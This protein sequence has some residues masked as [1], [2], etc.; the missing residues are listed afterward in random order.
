[1][2]DWKEAVKAISSLPVRFNV[3]L[4]RLTTFRIGGPVECL[5]EPDH[6][7]QLS[8]LL[9]IAKKFKLP[10]Y[11]L[12]RGSNLLAPDDPLPGLAIKLGRGFQ[13]VEQQGE[14]V[15]AG[16]GTPNGVLVEQCRKWGLGGLEFLIAV[17]GSI[18][19]AVAMN[20]GAH[21]AETAAFIRRVRFLNEQDEFQELSVKQSDFGYR[22]SQFRAPDRLVVGAW[23]QPNPSDSDA[24]KSKVV[25]FQSYRRETQPREFPNCGSVF[26]NPEGDHAGRLIEAVGLKGH[27]IGQAQISEKHANFIVN[28][29]GAKSSEVIEL[30]NLMSD[31]VYK[32]YG[33]ELALELQILPNQSR[34]VGFH[35]SSEDQSVKDVEGG[36]S[37]ND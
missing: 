35:Q 22:T 14:L 3:P 26:R 6:E 15:F 11:V 20:A 37:G 13:V 18:G 28:H 7:Q 9:K 10:V 33:I 5:A 16:A 2:M 29:G 30:I 25:S 12:G 23:F 36:R 19:G 34:W 27:R 31:S 4:S 17:P 21:N 1:M 8:E 32:K 24:V